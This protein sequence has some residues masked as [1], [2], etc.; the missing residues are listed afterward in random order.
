MWEKGDERGEH[1][2]AQGTFSVFEIKNKQEDPWKKKQTNLEILCSSWC[3]LLGFGEREE[4]KTED[5]IQEKLVW[6]SEP[7]RNRGPSDG[8]CLGS[9][10]P[11]FRERVPGTLAYRPGLLQLMQR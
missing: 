11:S 5:S 3:V 2:R 9:L 8:V 6:G 7:L 10:F 4:N 1:R